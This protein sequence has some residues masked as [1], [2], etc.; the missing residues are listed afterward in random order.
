MGKSRPTRNKIRVIDGIS[1]YAMATGRKNALQELFEV[2]PRVIADNHK[3]KLNKKEAGEYFE[4]FKLA[5]STE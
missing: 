4:L 2:L 3:Y 5:F 1:F